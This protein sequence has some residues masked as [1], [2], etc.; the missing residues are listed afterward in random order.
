MTEG[1][2]RG[3]RPTT[4]DVFTGLRECLVDVVGTAATA[5]FLRRAA[6]RASVLRPELATIAITKGELD[7]E[8]ALP[9]SWMTTRDGLPALAV[10]SGELQL[11]LHALTG[12]VL[13]RRLRAVPLLFEAGL[14]AEAERTA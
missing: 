4:S 3:D 12:D 1:G 9:A 13:V 2:N 11:L 6:R 10:L 14:F 5:T 8:Y 7:Y